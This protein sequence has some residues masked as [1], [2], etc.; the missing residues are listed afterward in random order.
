MKKFILV[1]LLSFTFIGGLIAEALLIPSTAELEVK[2]G[3]FSLDMEVALIE[4][5]GIWEVSSKVKGV[6]SREE[7]E[8][9][10]LNDESILPIDYSRKQRILFRKSESKAIFNWDD[11]VLTFKENRKKGSLDL[12]K[13]VLGPSSATLKLRIDVKLLGLDNLPNIIK[14]KVYYNK[15]IK[16]RT[17]EFKGL[18]KIST[19]MGDME[20]LKVSRVFLK[21]EN[22]KQIYWLSPKY[23]FSIVKI[24]DESAERK[25]D[26]RIK[27]IAF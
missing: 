19:P 2:A 25:S 1:N 24:I 4:T 18:E 16:E 12:I 9:F 27:S 17:Y 14:Y 11:E 23:D 10:I 7:K 8:T 3:N 13:G 15:E 21:G 5:D 6:A 26:V 20:A 22:R